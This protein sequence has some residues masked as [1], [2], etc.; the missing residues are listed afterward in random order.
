MNITFE[1]LAKNS[2]VISLDNDRLAKFYSIFRS[3]GWPSDSLPE[4]VK[5]VLLIGDVPKE[6]GCSMAHAKVLKLAKERDLPF[7]LIFEDDAYPRIDFKEHIEKALADLPEDANGC[8]LGFIGTNNNDYLSNNNITFPI[9][10]CGTS[11]YG[12]HAYII[13]KDRYDSTINLMRGSLHSDI[14]LNRILGM[15]IVRD[16]I[17]IQHIN[18]D[19]MHF[20]KPGYIYIINQHRNVR[21]MDSLHTKI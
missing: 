20:H 10:R 1:D 12:S 4:H 3:I 21:Q 15:Y 5:G 9:Y 17:F 8:M 2:F 16:P 11:F 13:F 6:F 19:G 7:C 14:A 18:K